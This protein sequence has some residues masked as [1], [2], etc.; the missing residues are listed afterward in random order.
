MV[1]SSQSGFCRVL[2][3]GALVGSMFVAQA[4]KAD[5]FNA[6]TDFNSTGVQTAGAIWTY[7]AETS[8][9]GTG[10]TLIPNFNSIVCNSTDNTCSPIGATQLV[11]STN[12]AYHDPYPSLMDNASAS[13]ITYAV[14]TLAN[15][16]GVNNTVVFPNDVLA[17]GPAGDIEVV[18]L[19]VP[20]GG[21]YNISGFFL[22]LQAASDGLDIVVDGNLLFQNLT[23]FTGATALQG[24]VSFSLTDIH[25]D[26]HDTIDFIVD[27]TYPG[28]TNDDLVGLAATVTKIP[29]PASVALLTSSLIAL[30]LLTWL[31]RITPL[32]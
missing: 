12:G 16:V 23:A 1:F 10:F 32:V 21:R 20:T 19:T 7:G 4:T 24:S 15:G 30:F 14:G 13:T 8:L 6:V 25:L 31:T 18:R 11:Y 27:G 2:K 3:F 9:N 17:L 5:V 22:D 28:G 29:E 26:A